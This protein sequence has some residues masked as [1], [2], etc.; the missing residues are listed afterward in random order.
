MLSK[1]EA[2]ALVRFSSRL[3]HLLVA[4]MMMKR[5]AERLGENTEEWELTGLLHDLDIDDARDDMSRHGIITAERLKGKLPQHCLHAIE[6]HDFRS[7]VVPTSRLDNALIAVDS[8]AILVERMKESSQKPDTVALKR[9][10]SAISREQPWHRDNILKC[11]E[12]GIELDEFLNLCL[13]AIER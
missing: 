3:S 7:G 8:T 11:K 4:S 13:G 5:L 1:D 10:I 2:A 9:E 6:A 12:I